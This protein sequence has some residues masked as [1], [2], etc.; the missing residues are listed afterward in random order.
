MVLNSS[1]RDVLQEVGVF[2]FRLMAVIEGPSFT[3]LARTLSVPRDAFLGAPEPDFLAGTAPEGDSVL[4]LLACKWSSLSPLIL[5]LHV[6]WT[7]L[8]LGG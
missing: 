2:S 4:H 6:W 1:H 7:S 8:R 3:S 5:P